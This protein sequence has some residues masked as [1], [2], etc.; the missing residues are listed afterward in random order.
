[1]EG[2]LT[3]VEALGRKWSEFYLI[4]RPGCGGGQ[5]P[6]RA[7]GFLLW[8][9]F[10]GLRHL[11]LGLAK[12]LR[13]SSSQWKPGLPTQRPVVCFLLVQG[14]ALRFSLRGS[15]ALLM[16]RLEA[17]DRSWGAFRTQ[18]LLGPNGYHLPSLPHPIPSASSWFLRW[19]EP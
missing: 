3:A 2:W 5:D 8:F 16:A 1:M 15:P 13:P 6:S 14:A 4:G 7:S 17:P 10:P 12:A 19:E 11:S 18:L 9:S